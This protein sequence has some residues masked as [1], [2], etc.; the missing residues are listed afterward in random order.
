[1]LFWYHAYLSIVFIYLFLTTVAESSLG[2][3]VGSEAYFVFALLGG[4]I[5]NI[6]TR[7][8]IC[9]HCMILLPKYLDICY[10]NNCVGLTFE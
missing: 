5:K 1:M 2:L 10:F 8:E 3:E 7:G 4:L 9:G 6:G